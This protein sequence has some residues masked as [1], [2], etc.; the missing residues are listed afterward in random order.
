MVRGAGARCAKKTLAASRGALPG[1]IK[2]QSPLAASALRML[3]TGADQAQECLRR[4]KASVV[5]AVDCAAPSLVRDEKVRFAECFDGSVDSPLS[6]VAVHRV[7]P[8]GSFVQGSA[9]MVCRAT[10]GRASP[11]AFE[12]KSLISAMRSPRLW[13]RRLA[14]AATARA[15]A[16]VSGGTRLA[17]T[18]G[19]VTVGASAEQTA[20]RLVPVRRFEPRSRG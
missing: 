11:R 7:T 4:I 8:G 17:A 15:A 18:S 6:K 14:N 12:P 19:S 5:E 10:S 16:G 1:D 2:G 3:C 20:L 13:R 9:G